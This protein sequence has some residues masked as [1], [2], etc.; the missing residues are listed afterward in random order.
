M[1]YKDEQKGKEHQKQYYLKNRD[2]IIARSAKRYKDK[3][4]EISAKSRE[5]YLKNRK[6]TGEG[7]GHGKGKKFEKGFTPWNKGKKGCQVAWNKGMGEWRTEEGRL[8]FIKALRGRIPW[9]KGKPSLIR[10]EK[11]HNWKGGITPENEKAR[12]SLEYALWRKACLER[13]N[14]TCHVSGE[15]GGKLVVHHI[16]NFADFP[17]LR[18]SITNGITMTKKLHKEF[19]KRYGVKNNTKEQLEEFTHT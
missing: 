16:N 18:T 17:E 1:P 7:S 8:K 3:K 15:S 10:G 11:H 6:L 13:D 4:K 19:H 2:K 9:N 14:F 5:Y 12:R